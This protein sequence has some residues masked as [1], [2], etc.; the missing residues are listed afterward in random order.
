MDYSS[1]NLSPIVIDDLDGHSKILQFYDNS[2]TGLG[3]LIQFW[4]KNYFKGTLEVW[5]RMSSTTHIADFII[6]DRM[7][8][9]IHLRFD[10]NGIMRYKARTSFYDIRM[11]QADTWIHLKFEW[12]CNDD[13]H[14]WINGIS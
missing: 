10:A 7:F 1:S 12:D 2:N 6:E 11:Y 8:E 3:G 13:W 5:L 9:S 14:L 4:G